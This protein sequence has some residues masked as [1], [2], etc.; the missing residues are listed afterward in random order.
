LKS[1]SIL[2]TGAGGFI[3]KR[4]VAKALNLGY[5]V[6][7]LESNSA[8]ADEVE[9]EFGIEV[10]LGSIA[11]KEIRTMALKKIS[12]VINTV[13]VMKEAGDI[14]EF[15]KINVEATYQLAD[16]AKKAGAKV[17]VHLSSVMVYGFHYPPFVTEIGPL[18]GTGSAYAQ[19]KIEGEH[20]LLPLNQANKYGV[21]ILRP[22][23]VYG[24]GS[25]PW[26]TRPL[27]V[28][29]KGL[30]ALPSGGEG[31]MNLTYVDNLADAVFLAIDQKVFG[32]IINITDGK[33]IT[34]K[35]YFM[36]L[37]RIAKRPLPKSLPYAVAKTLVAISSPFF[38][39]FQGES[40]LSPEGIDFIMRPHPVSMEKSKRL[41]NFVPKVSYK[42]GLDKTEEWLRSK[43][44]LR[45]K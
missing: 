11:N 14:D 40:P 39:L 16:E 3:G 23:D 27:Q 12:T 18:D 9:R 41:L 13:A 29:D 28:M 2:I 24:P 26:V 38:K 34:W 15:R 37:A 33:P 45:Q 17:F 19:T 1:K 22:G 4:L 6:V 32:E 21:I 8:R 20:A 35:E 31:M 7:G 43:N 10:I 25:E 36:D 5:K 42:E 30:F 44:Y